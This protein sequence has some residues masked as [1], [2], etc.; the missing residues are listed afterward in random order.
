MCFS[1]RPCS[2]HGTKQ[3]IPQNWK[4][5]LHSFNFFLFFLAILVNSHPTPFG[6]TCK[7]SRL[8]PL[9][10]SIG[11]FWRMAGWKA[12]WRC[13]YVF[14]EKT[15]LIIP[16]SFYVVFL[17]LYFVLNIII[18]LHPFFFFFPFAYQSPSYFL[19]DTYHLGVCKEPVLNF[20]T[21]QRRLAQLR[22]LKARFF[23]S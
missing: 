17:S 22:E 1:V 13:K 18:I 5:L 16:Y 11:L 12:A 6:L 9:Q 21:D 20:Q 10:L 23:L 19:P 7:T 2:C 14:R 3:I 4:Q 15:N 8:Q